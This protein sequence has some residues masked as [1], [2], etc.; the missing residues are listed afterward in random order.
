[1]DARRAEAREERL[2]HRR[3]ALHGGRRAEDEENGLRALHRLDPNGR[4]D[5]NARI[6]DRRSRPANET[7]RTED[8][9]VRLIAA[10]AVA[11]VVPAF[12]LAATLP[13]LDHNGITADAWTTVDR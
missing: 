1:D 13:P 9:A 2:R 10:A 11:L 7:A 4:L 5:P 8:A 3:A 12:A 6:L